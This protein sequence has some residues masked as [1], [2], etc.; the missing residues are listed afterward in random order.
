VYLTDY[1]RLLTALRGPRISNRWTEQTKYETRLAFMYQGNP[2][3]SWDYFS[4]MTISFGI[5]IWTQMVLGGKKLVKLNV[6][7]IITNLSSV[8]IS[9]SIARKPLL[10]QSLLIVEASRSTSVRHTTVSR[11]PLDEWSALRRDLSL[12]TQGTRNRQTSM[13]RRGSN[14]QF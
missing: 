8:Y 10:G 7:I 3:S 14:P 13:P 2:K 6:Y 4:H 9:F 11:I 1:I 5:W 12:T